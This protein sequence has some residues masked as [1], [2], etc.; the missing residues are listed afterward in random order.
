MVV[1]IQENA[2]STSISGASAEYRNIG[3]LG[4]RVY[5][6]RLKVYWFLFYALIPKPPTLHSEPEPEA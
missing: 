5:D 3:A 2:N 6:S 1:S 4:L